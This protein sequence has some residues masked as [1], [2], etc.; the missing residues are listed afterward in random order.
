MTD[1]FSERLTVCIDAANLSGYLALAPTLSLLGDQGID[2][3]WLPLTWPL[4]RLSARQPNETAI[5]PL[6]AYKARRARAREKWARRELERDC[7]RLGITVAAGARRFD[8]RLAGIGLMFLNTRGGDIPA[9]LERVYR[10]AF[11]EKMG[12]E[13]AQEIATLVGDDQFLA[14]EGGSGPAAL[15]SIQDQLLEAGVFGSPAYVLD[16]EVFQGREHLPLLNSLLR[17]HP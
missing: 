3:G 6:A 4:E 17:R 7:E 15:D 10:R 5:D 11:H 2:A 13:S 14:F 16:G 1:L 12:V 9:Y 8:S